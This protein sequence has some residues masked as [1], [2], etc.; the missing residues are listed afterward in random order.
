MLFAQTSESPE[1]HFDEFSAA[2]A[3]ELQEGEEYMA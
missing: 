1:N 2:K 3:Y